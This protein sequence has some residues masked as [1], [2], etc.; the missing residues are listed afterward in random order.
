[1]CAARVIGLRVLHPRGSE[2]SGPLVVVLA[3]G[4]DLI[5]GHEAV[6]H[7]EQC[8]TGSVGLADLGVDVLDVVAHGLWR[9][10]QPLSDLPV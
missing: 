7:G 3:A 1:M 2:R 4:V 9:D 10:R 6:P 8:C 5:C